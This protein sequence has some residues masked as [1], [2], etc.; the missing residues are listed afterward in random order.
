MIWLLSCS[1]AKTQCPEKTEPHYACVS[2]PGEPVNCIC[3]P[4]AFVSDER[5]KPGVQV[6]ECADE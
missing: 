5:Q 4:D 6:F 1:E 2:H 3:V